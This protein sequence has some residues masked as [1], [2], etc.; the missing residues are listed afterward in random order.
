MSEIWE[1]FN[2]GKEKHVCR[3]CPDEFA[4]NKSGATSHLWRHIEVKHPNIYKETNKGKTES[5]K[6]GHGQE[7][8]ESPCS[9]KQVKINIAQMLSPGFSKSKSEEL[10]NDIAD[11]LIMHNLPFTLTESPCLKRIALKN[12]QTNSV[13]FFLISHN[14]ILDAF[15]TSCSRY[16]S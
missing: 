1:H 15:T 9:S 13:C 5:R 2:K 3:H 11:L 7:K 16:C 14:Q 12:Y 10:A 6:R 8:P 4:V